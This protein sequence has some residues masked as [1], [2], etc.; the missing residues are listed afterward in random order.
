M[1]GHSKWNNIK[2]RKGAQ[3]KL[4]SK[5]FS[6]LSRLIRAAARSGNSGDPKSNPSLRLVLDK[7]RLANMPKD[8]VQKAIDVGLGKT[9]GKQIQE[10]V[11]EAFGP[12]GVGMMIVALTD[13]VNRSSAEIRFILSKAGGSLGSPGSAKYMFSRNE[14]GE[15]VA[16]MKLDCS[17]E[18]QARLLELMDNLR[19]FEDVEDV[20]VAC[21]LVDNTLE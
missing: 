2:N 20:F 21:D 8:K 14:E 3:D 18:D 5:A 17:G 19:E 16:T 13:N 9:D 4:K 12:G 6:Q 7:A 15:F 1:S 11:Y 10:I